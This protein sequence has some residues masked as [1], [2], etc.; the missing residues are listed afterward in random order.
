M[1]NSLKLATVAF[2]AFG[3]IATATGIASAAGWFRE[4]SA[5]EVQVTTAAMPDFDSGP[6]VE[7]KNGNVK[8]DWIG[9]RIAKGAPV[10]RYVV[11]RYNAVTD[12]GAQVCGNAV[13]AT[14]C[15]DT[16][17]PAGKWR[18][19]VRAAQGLW[20]GPESKRSD[21]I[22]IE[23]TAGSRSAEVAAVLT[24]SPAATPTLSTPPAPAAKA[25]AQGNDSPP[26]PALPSTMEPDESKTASSEQSTPDA[27]ATSDP[28]PADTPSGI[29][30][31]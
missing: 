12:V 15:I 5:V 27:T 4:E 3:C 20:L 17:V 29:A 8:V 11:T 21:R 16:A 1:R 22:V 25:P 6:A 24:N 14:K 10:E 9:Q 26:P 18:Y 13:T 30:I 23:P 31:D 19:T 7:L 2:G 28:A